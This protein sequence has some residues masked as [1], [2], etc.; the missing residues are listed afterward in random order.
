[1]IIPIG[2]EEEK[3]MR[4]PWVTI[5]LIVINVG[6]FL[7]TSQV[8]DQQG[9]ATRQQLQ[10]IVQYVRQ[11]PY[12]RLP[13]EMRAGL[14][15]PAP[16][17]TVSPW[18][19][20]EEQAKLDGMWTQFRT[21][22]EQGIYYTYGY[23]PARPSLLALVTSMFLHGGWLHLLGNMLFLWLAGAA[24][25]DRWGRVFFP[26]LYL[27]SGVVGTLAHGMM[28]QEST[29]P[30]VGASGAVAGLM[31]AFLLRL[32]T[33]KIRF[34]YWVFLF[35]GTFS[36]PAWVALPL[37]LLQ[38]F[39][40][41]TAGPGGI[42]VWAHIGGFAVGFAVAAALRLTDFESRVLAPSV[43]KKTTWSPSDQLTEALARL[44]AGDADGAVRRLVAILR[45]NPNSID[46]RAA[47]VHAYTSKEDDASAGRESGRLVSAY[48]VARDI[49]GALAAYKEH[50]RAHPDVPIR[51]R[52]ALALAGHFEKSESYLEAAAL[53]RQGIENWPDDPLMPKLLVSYGRLL[54]EGMNRP[55]DAAE[56]LEQVRDHPKTTPDFLKASQS[57]LQRIQPAEAAAAPPAPAP[58]PPAPEP[59]ATAPRIEPELG[60]L[61]PEAEPATPTWEIGAPETP[62]LGVQ[63]DAQATPTWELGAPESPQPEAQP[64]PQVA[65][66]TWEQPSFE[67]PDSAAP[68]PA[69]PAPPAEEPGYFLSL[70]D[71]VTLDGPPQPPEPPKPS[72]RLVP[73]SMRAVGIDGRGLHIVDQDGKAGRL[74]WQEVAALSIASV[75]GPSAQSD[76]VA[77]HLIL[78][79]LMAPLGPGEAEVQCIR[80]AG[81]DLAIPQLQSEPP[82]RAAQRLAATIL[83]V[84]NATPY[85]SREECL[86]VRGFAVY[87]DLETYEADLL[88]RLPTEEP[89]T[90]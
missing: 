63:P 9:V 84:A 69:A 67:M 22:K 14:R 2:H 52:D 50:T 82:V 6:L 23:V 68:A 37:W 7:G 3:V 89:A 38:Q 35:T 31:G 60:E 10:E 71:T 34:F 13:A 19:L 76:P 62:E 4:L 77:T 65:A 59:E 27:T 72:R 42:A 29:L 78:D 12:L 18:T 88:G 70:D 54:L 25:E 5:C 17:A 46:A 58:P 8:A 33:T 11:H 41:A 44:D 36:M 32:A 61:E 48:V 87:P 56:V 86:G 57:L 45:V 75:G 79:M 21:T 51:L 83:K 26:I 74:P 53:Y 80:V 90:P 1:M 64:E 24:L 66:P 40:M 28:N 49:E 39:W 55:A 47:L 43:V 16:P 15:Q 30:M 85:P 20:S 81:P 73:I